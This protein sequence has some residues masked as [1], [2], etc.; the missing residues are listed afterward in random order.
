[1]TFGVAWWQAVVRGWWGCRGQ[2][3]SCSRRS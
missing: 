3:Q 1:M 2:V